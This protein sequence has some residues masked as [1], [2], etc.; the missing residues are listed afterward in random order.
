MTEIGVAFLPTPMTTQQQAKELTKIG[1]TSRITNKEAGSRQV[2][3]EGVWSASNMQCAPGGSG[4]PAS[5]FLPS[6]QLT[7]EESP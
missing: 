5:T 2:G 1:T 3:Q 6:A 7:W 4:Q